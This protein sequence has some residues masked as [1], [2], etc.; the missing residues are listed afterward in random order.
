MYGV[1]KEIHCLEIAAQNGGKTLVNPPEM[2]IFPGDFVPGQI[3]MRGYRA[4]ASM[5]RY[6]E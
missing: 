4:L 3:K 5:V 1:H 2:K 6:V